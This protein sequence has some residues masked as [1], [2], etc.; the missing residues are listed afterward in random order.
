MKTKKDKRPRPP[1]LRCS[2][3]FAVALTT[4]NN[5]KIPEN[6]IRQKISGQKKSV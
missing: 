2:K 6:Q 1:S 5:L 3:P 4:G